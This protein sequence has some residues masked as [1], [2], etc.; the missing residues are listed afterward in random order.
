MENNRNQKV[1]LNNKLGIK[2]IQKRDNGKYRARI[3]VDGNLI[4]LGTFETIEEAK[5]ARADASKHYF[6]EFQSRVERI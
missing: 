4:N 6:K 5:K 3:R 2:G 1:S